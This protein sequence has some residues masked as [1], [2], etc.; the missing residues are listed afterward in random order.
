MSR[1]E[2]LV[3]LDIG[4]TKVAALVGDVSP[5]GDV[6]IIGIGVGPSTGMRK[7]VVVDIDGTVRSIQ[8]AVDS[9]RR[10]SGVDVKS[11]FLGVGGAHISSFRNRGVV[12]V[13]RE[14]RD[15]TGADVERVLDA[16][17]VVSIPP[18]REIIHVLP[19]GYVVDGYD[20]IRDPE[21]MMGV[22][23]EVEAGIVTAAVTSL[24][25]LL[26][27]VYKAGLE[28]DDVVL[29]PLASGEAVA[30]S[31]E[32]DLGVVVADIGGGSTDIALFDEGS[33]WFASIIPVAGSHITG[34]IAV[35]LRTPI[36]EAERAKVEHGVAMEGLAGEGEVFPVAGI[37]GGRTREV[38]LADM[39]SIIEPRVQEI[40][41]MVGQEIKRSG[42][43]KVIPGGL[44]LTGG[45][46][47]LRGLEEM[48]ANYLEM[49]VR[50]G[51]PRGVGGLT[52]VARHPGYATAVGTLLFAAKSLDGTRARPVSTRA[53]GLLEKIGS[54]FRGM[55]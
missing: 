44:V 48:A 6:N 18:D 12:A 17:R 10:M 22:R 8:A 21:G 30:Q 27:S 4:S 26:R 3:A 2:P 13:S 43:G 34:D 55:F 36:A 24:Q 16:A 49:P 7:G 20:G 14:D 52:D 46:S 42:Y 54:F 39:A 41:S 9:A 37:S 40:L 47:L 45:T 32:K 33:L 5:S 31:A 50:V 15:I 53:G 19:R 38:P 28:V 23:L 29:N 11:V 25:N 51:V 1:R 35:G